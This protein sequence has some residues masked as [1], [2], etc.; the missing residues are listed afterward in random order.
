MGDAADDV[1]DG[2]DGGDGVASA[3][4]RNSPPCSA[5]DAAD[6]DATRAGGTQS[7]TPPPISSQSAANPPKIIVYA[8]KPHVRVVA[9]PHVF[10]SDGASDSMMGGEA[11]THAH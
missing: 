11:G 7:G 9:G 3:M 2:G 8:T 10:L 6:V 4:Y 5:T 1:D